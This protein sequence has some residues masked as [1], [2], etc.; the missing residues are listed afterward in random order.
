MVRSAFEGG[1][2]QFPSTAAS[3]RVSTAWLKARMMA[4]MEVAINRPAKPR[5]PQGSEVWT[6]GCPNFVTTAKSRLINPEPKTETA[7]PEHRRWRAVSS[8]PRS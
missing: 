3:F 8:F 4:E 1:G 7:Q 6:S 2:A 5:F